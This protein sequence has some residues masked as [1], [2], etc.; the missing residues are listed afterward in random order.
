MAQKF[1]KKYTKETKK[2][3][4]VKRIAKMGDI[5]YKNVSVLQKCLSSRHKIVPRRYT[6]LSAKFQR[7]LAKEIKKARFLA[8][9]KYTERQ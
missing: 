2:R 7:K 8:L 3:E 9:L 6:G 4:N 1:E 5:D